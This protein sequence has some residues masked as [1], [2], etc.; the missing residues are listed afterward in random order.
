[1]IKTIICRFTKHYSNGIVSELRIFEY[2]SEYYSTEE[3]FVQDKL[4]HWGEYEDAAGHNYGYTSEADILEFKDLTPEEIKTLKERSNR[5]IEGYK[6]D[7][8][9]H[10]K[11]INFLNPRKHKLLKIKH[12]S[13]RN[14]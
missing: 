7:I 13:E 1:M 10:E 6:N 11:I 8:K 3:S 4:E 12:E 14:N 5:L 9:K 2:D